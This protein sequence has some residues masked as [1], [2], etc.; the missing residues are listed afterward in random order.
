[1]QDAGLCVRV[2]VN[3]KIQRRQ[4]TCSPRRPHAPSS[5]R[6]AGR[7]RDVGSAWQ[8]QLLL[9]LTCKQSLLRRLLDCRVSQCQQWM[10]CVAA[11]RP[12][13]ADDTTWRGIKWPSFS[14]PSSAC[15]RV[16][17]RR[18]QR[19]HRS[20]K[21]FPAQRQFQLGGHPV[22]QQYSQDDQEGNMRSDQPER[23]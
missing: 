3:V 22:K 20:V 23:L 13:S 8:Y 5:A 18:H 15:G 19:V 11:D 21:A 7:P 2:R 16:W 1:M 12:H 17:P 10:G 4:H 6:W 14:G 9:V